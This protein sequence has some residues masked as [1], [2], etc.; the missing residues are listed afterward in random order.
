MMETFILMPKNRTVK[1]VKN[2]CNPKS[3][4]FRTGLFGNRPFGVIPTGLFKDDAV[5]VDGDDDSGF[6]RG[7]P[8]LRGIGVPGEFKP[9][10]SSSPSL[11]SFFNILI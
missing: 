8:F 6:K 3:F 10:A 7:R 5:L 9:S 1:S 4:F 2:F 11:S